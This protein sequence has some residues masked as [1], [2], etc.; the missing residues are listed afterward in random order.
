MQITKE[1]LL[2]D[3]F[4]ISEQKLGLENTLRYIDGLLAFL[5]RPEAAPEMAIEEQQEPAND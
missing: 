5:D 1:N 2:A 4:A 3:K